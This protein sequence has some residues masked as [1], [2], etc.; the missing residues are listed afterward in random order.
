MPDRAA[1]LAILAGLPMPA[2]GIT[3]EAVQRCGIGATRVVVPDE[4]DYHHRT[5]RRGA[6]PARRHPAPRRVRSRATAVFERLASVEG[7]I[8]GV[9]PATVE[10]HEVGS[11]DAIVDVVGTCAALEV[12]GVDEVRAASVALSVGTVRG[13]HGIL[14]NPAPAVVALLAEAGVPSHGL[15]LPFELTTPD[16]RGAARRDGVGL[17]ADCRP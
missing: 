9:D 5:L 6:R 17:R 15:D 10:F 4:P 14:P 1:V 3:F 8:H 2:G 12:L 7:R 13:S 11:L 16:R